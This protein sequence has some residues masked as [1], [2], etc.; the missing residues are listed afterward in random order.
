MRRFA[1]AQLPE[2]S[3]SSDEK[4]LRRNTGAFHYLTAKS[5]ASLS[6]IEIASADT[7]KNKA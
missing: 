7:Y 5:G 6:K 1:K 3:L 2:Y 4:K